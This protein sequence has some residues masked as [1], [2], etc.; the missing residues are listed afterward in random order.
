MSRT[1]KWHQAR[2]F[3]HQGLVTVRTRNMLQVETP[4]DAKGA[5]NDPLRCQATLQADSAILPPQEDTTILISLLP[6]S[7]RRECRELRLQ[8]R[9]NSV[10]FA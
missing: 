3:Q 1:T 5:C 10:H 6:Q 9:S 2:E 4:I 7:G 8:P